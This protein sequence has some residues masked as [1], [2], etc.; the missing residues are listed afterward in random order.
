MQRFVMRF[1]LLNIYWMTMKYALLHNGDRF[2]FSRLVN[3]FYIEL[4]CYRKFYCC[5]CI[6]VWCIFILDFLLTLCT[7]FFF[8]AISICFIHRFIHAFLKSRIT[9]ILNSEE[10]SK[11]KSLI[12]WQNQ[13]IKHIK[14][15]DNNCQVFLIAT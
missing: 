5:E 4:C 6:I 10:N 12:K 15:M 2:R 8:K 14:R 13:M 3:S 7:V 9:K 11:Q 1:V